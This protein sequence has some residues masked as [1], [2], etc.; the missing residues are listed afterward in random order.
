LK[1]IYQNKYK[2]YCLFLKEWILSEE[3]KRVK[4]SKIA[5]NRHK[6]QRVNKIAKVADST[7]NTTISPNL[8]QLIQNRFDNN[9]RMTT[10]FTNFKEHNP[11]PSIIS[12]NSYRK[13]ENNLISSSS[14][15]NTEA[16]NEF[17]SSPNKISYSFQIP[18]AIN[19]NTL[20]DSTLKNLSFNDFNESSIPLPSSPL[21]SIISSS[22]S[23][24]TRTSSKFQTIESNSAQKRYVNQNPV[25]TSFAEINNNCS[26]TSDEN[27][28]PTFGEIK[29]EQKF[30]ESLETVVIPDIVYEKTIEVEFAQIPI[31]QTITEM[32]TNITELNQLE[33]NRLNELSTAMNVL[34]IP[35]PR[36]TSEATGLVDAIKMTDQAIRR[37]IKMS[38]K[39]NAFK[40]LCQSDQIALLKAGCTEMIIL[41]SVMTFNYESEYWTVYNVCIQ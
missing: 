4:R 12:Y 17:H 1:I 6:R 31:R 9:E 32:N 5:E 25:I 26:N 28:K 34:K 40:S 30:D 27:F 33:N 41:R 24:S 14:E 23:D 10:N 11:L 19:S 8:I 15:L 20:C 2:L 16:Q 18:N 13:S 29:T 36:I 38:K 3:E 37:V 21:T 35:L 7:T 22:S 39:I